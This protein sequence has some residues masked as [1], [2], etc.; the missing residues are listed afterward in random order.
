[1]NALSI[2][3]FWQPGCSACVKVKEFLRGLGVPFESVDVL[4]DA[5][6]AADLRRLGA[7]SLP[8]VSRGS[9][10]VFGQSLDQ[11]ANFVGVKAKS[12]VRRRRL[13]GTAHD[14]RPAAVLLERG[15]KFSP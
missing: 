15:I 2:R 9:K 3:V 4:N 10:F 12:A 5:E 6:G 8:V 13:D 7:S 14:R 11:V 1:V